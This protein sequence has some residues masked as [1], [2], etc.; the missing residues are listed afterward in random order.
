MFQ[1]VEQEI[2][3]KTNEELE[4]ILISCLLN[5][6]KNSEDIFLLLSPSDF[7][8]DN[9]RLIFAAANE[10]RKESKITDAVTLISYIDSNS[11][12]QFNDYNNYIKLLSTKY[13]YD[14]NVKAYI[15]IVKNNSI[16]RQLK[17]FGNSLSEI[18]MDVTN[19]GEILWDLEK[20]FLDI[21]NSNKT[22]DVET[23]S[24]IMI[25]YHKKLES[26]KGRI[27]TLTGTTSG[28]YELDKI[29]NGFQPEDLIILAA[30]PGI[31]KT[32]IALN[33]LL[34]AAKEFAEWNLKKDHTEK[35]KM[36][37]MFSME[38]GNNQISERLVSIQ[39]GV[40]ISVNKRGNWNE[41][42]WLSNIDAIS[43][44]SAYP[45]YIDDSSNL[46]IIDIQSKLKQL[47]INKEV[48]LIVIDYLQLLKGP[49]TK[50]QQVNRQQEVASISR[51]LKSI[52]R[53]YNV[54]IIAISQLS[55][56]IEERKGEYRRPI[57]SAL[58]E[59]G[60][61]EQDAD[62]VS[63]LNYKVEEDVYNKS[64]K[65]NSDVVVEYII[66]KHRNGATDSVDLLFKKSI[67][68]YI[69]ISYR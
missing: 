33:F 28:Y 67:G 59:S 45:I 14:P 38:M 23:L 63:F 51:T 60:A 18:N 42:Q 22:K 27:E 39:S 66:A 65:K 68:K 20:R 15:E 50:S 25:E 55:R 62:I 57:L 29:T 61:I 36:V 37:L 41:T 31:G 35:E 43:S 32:A 9:N 46:S 11:S 12:F 47:S 21:T 5:K 24:E 17:S 54:P 49:N 26:M 8:S 58:R 19:N 69:P 6:H 30:R 52:A 44:L 48:K 64:D 40:D 1:E 10:L 34:N 13:N 4:A 3:D 16:I 2:K 53:Q 7:G 56:K